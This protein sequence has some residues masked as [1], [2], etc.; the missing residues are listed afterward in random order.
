MTITIED[1]VRREVIH[2]AGLMIADLQRLVP[3]APPNIVRNLSFDSEDLDRLVEL[4]NYEEPV[5]DYID[6][7]DRDELA[8]A[9]DDAGVEDERDP[10]V[11]RAASL[12]QV[13]EEG[14][15]EQD[16]NEYIGSWPGVPEKEMREKLLAQLREDDSWEEFADTHRVEP[17]Y[18]EVYEFWIVTDWLGAKLKDKGHPVEEICSMTIWGRPTTG[19]AISMDGVIGEIYRETM[20]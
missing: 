7:M 8:E 15:D 18:D 17:Y 14:G 20:L 12:A 19:Q 9:L 2:H 1:F 10:G 13:L 5:G 6:K 4:R 3:E 11:I 16:G